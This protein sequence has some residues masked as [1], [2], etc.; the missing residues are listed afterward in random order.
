MNKRKI[1]LSHVLYRVKD[2]HLAVSLLQKAGFIV[3]Y[4]T[5]P[6]KAYNAIIWF[7]E[8]VFIE[9][10]HNSGLSAPIRWM[11]KLFGYQPVLN[12]INK[13]NKIENGWCE[14]SL[15]ST[16]ENL[17]AEREFFTNENKSFKFHK[18]KRKDANQQILRWELLMPNDIYFPFIMSAYNPNPRPREINHP[19][20]IKFV[21]RLIVGQNNLDISLLENLLLEKTALQL[22]KEGTGIQSVEFE[23]SSLKIENILI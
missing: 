11:M 14:W 10:Y 2:L 22:V 4:G 18:A 23:N 17:N 12:R 8:G 5:D 20:G 6:E 15:E 21:S 1:Q 9:I 16:L 3:E 19:N 13:W 7:D